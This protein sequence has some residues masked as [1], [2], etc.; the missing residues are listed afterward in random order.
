VQAVP[1]P[2]PEP[3]GGGRGASGSGRVPGAVPA[4]GIDVAD[5]DPAWPR[6]YEELTSRIREALGWR[7]L[8]LEHVGSTSVPRLAAK[9]TRGEHVMQYNACKEQVIREIYHRAFVAA[10]LLEE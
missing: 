6:R 9:P 3:E 10:G 7:T 2:G 5:P 8:Q 4:T 1:V